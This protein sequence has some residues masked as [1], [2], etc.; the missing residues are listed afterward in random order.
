MQFIVKGEYS[1]FERDE[2]LNQAKLFAA[3]VKYGIQ[4]LSWM[5]MMSYSCACDRRWDVHEFLRSIP[6]IFD[7]DQD[8]F[9]NLRMV[10]VQEGI[11]AHIDAIKANPASYTALR[12]TCMKVPEFSFAMVDDFVRFPLYGQCLSCAQSKP[13]RP[14]RCV[15]ALG[16]EMSVSQENRNRGVEARPER[17]EQVARAA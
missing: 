13:L 3:A 17:A 8:A 12:S 1:D 11:R 10:A 7:S 2:F 4:K 16:S 9:H 14:A 6:F 15:C 5:A